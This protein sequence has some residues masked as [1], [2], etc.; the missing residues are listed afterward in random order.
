MSSDQDDDED[1][2]KET[3]VGTRKQ[4]DEALARR[5]RPEIDFGDTEVLA[6][7]ELVAEDEAATRIEAGRGL[8]SEEESERWL[9]DLRRPSTPPPAPVPARPPVATAG[10]PAGRAPMPAQALPGN[11][12]LAIAAPLPIA[13]PPAPA[14]TEKAA[15]AVLYRRPDPEA[16][17]PAVVGSVLLLCGILSAAG[18][19]ALVYLK[20]K[21]FW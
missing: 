18:T 2:N 10:H 13:A 11:A 21:G 20:L 17:L 15:E 16:G 4:L 12:P 8:F 19:M 3:L 7:P 1:G 14:P 6:D 9:T 5:P